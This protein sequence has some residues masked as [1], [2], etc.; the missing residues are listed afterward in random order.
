MK[1]KLGFISGVLGGLA[2]IGVGAWVLT[3][4]SGATVEARI[5]ILFP[6]SILCLMPLTIS[7]LVACFCWYGIK[8]NAQR[9]N[10]TRLAGTKGG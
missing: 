6:F 10:T 1:H 5:G 3:W 4:T 2:S 8:D 7:C 9:S